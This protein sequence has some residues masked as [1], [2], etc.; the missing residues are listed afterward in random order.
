MP[1]MQFARVLQMGDFKNIEL[2]YCDRQLAKQVCETYHY[3]KTYPQGAKVNIALVD[4]KKIVGII[5]FGYS[6]ATEKKVNSLTYGIDKTKYLEMQRLWISDDYG[7]NTESYVLAKAIKKLAKDYDLELIM[8]YAGGCKDDC[9]IVYQAS[10][11]LY[12]G[13]KKCDDFYY[14]EKGEYK[15]IAAAR[16]FGRIDVKSRTQQE[17]GEELFGPGCVV[18]AHRYFYIYPINKGIRR[19]LNKATLPYPKTSATFRKD[20]QWVTGDFAGASGA[21]RGGSTPPISTEV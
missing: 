8:T 4:N 11:W 5:V 19:R 13:A 16:K 17:L 7:H 14:T 10:G 1:F 12:F 2:K 21:S 9:G 6:S 18:N 3:M 20:Q 15:N